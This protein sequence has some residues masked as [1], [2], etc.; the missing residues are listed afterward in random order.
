MWS[1][2]FLLN[3]DALLRQMDRFEEAFDR[4]RRC[5]ADGDREEMRKIMRRSTEERAKFDKKERTSV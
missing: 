4:L 1:E 5:I 2:L 3:R